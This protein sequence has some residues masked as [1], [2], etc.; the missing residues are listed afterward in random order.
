MRAEKTFWRELHT[1]IITVVASKGNPW[2]WGA[3]ENKIGLA[4]FL[5]VLL[6]CLYYYVS[7]SKATDAMS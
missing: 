6:Y 2:G 4:F 3:V 1:T 5:H 7:A